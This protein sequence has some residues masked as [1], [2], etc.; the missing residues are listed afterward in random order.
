ML[1]KHLFMSVTKGN[2]TVN[3]LFGGCHENQICND[4]ARHY[5]GYTAK[6]DKK[7][8]NNLRR[9]IQR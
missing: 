7:R 1:S 8:S 3:C 5:I 6:T 2:T 4:D 9:I